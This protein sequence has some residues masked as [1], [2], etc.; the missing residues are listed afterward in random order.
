MQK[1]YFRL[2]ELTIIKYDPQKHFDAGKNIVQQKKRPSF[3]IEIILSRK[4]AEKS[5]T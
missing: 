1:F 3:K 4:Q 2:C 5:I